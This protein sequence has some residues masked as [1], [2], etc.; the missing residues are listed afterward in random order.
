LRFYEEGV[1]PRKNASVMAEAMAKLK[2]EVGSQP[3]AEDANG[4]AKKKKKKDKVWERVRAVCRSVMS[5]IQPASHFLVQKQGRGALRSVS[6]ACTCWQPTSESATRLAPVV[7]YPL[8]A[9]DTLLISSCRVFMQKKKREEAEEAANGAAE[10]APAAA[11][12]EE[13]DG[14][15]KKKKKKKDKKAKEED[16]E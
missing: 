5:G 14:E 8:H 9:A 2:E 4:E 16:D 11:A 13:G 10:E 3:E 7:P 12:A 6:S 15:P 1:A